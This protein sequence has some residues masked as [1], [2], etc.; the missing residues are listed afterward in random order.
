MSNRP[1]RTYQLF[2][3]SDV[4]FTESLASDLVGGENS[5]A[6][7]YTDITFLERVAIQIIW[8]T[9]NATGQFDIEVTNTPED[10]ASWDTLGLS[11]PAVASADGLF[12]ADIETAFPY[13]R[14]IYDTTF[15]ESANVAT[16]A[17]TAGSLNSKYFLIDGA[18]GNDWYV[19]YNINAA[20]V[21]PAISGRTGIVVA[22]AT[23]ASANTLATATRTALAACTS[24][25]TIGGATNNVSFVQD[26]AG[27]GAVT[28]GA[29]PTGFT[30][31][32][33]STDGV[34]SATLSAKEI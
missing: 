7:P 3:T 25:T 4:N 16:V 15:V 1:I 14:V 29:A 24:I 12:S 31:T 27:H 34:A 21:D 19:W 32:Y 9:S 6:T 33:T 30:I 22:G 26:T 28:D 18:D 2:K 5:S 10:E 20:G 23:G 17:D 11:I 13:I 8:D